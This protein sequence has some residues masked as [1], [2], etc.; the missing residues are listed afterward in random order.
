MSQDS[1]PQQTNLDS[2]IHADET[3]TP[4][5][6]VTT[7]GS[8]TQG[9]GKA[10]VRARVNGSSAPKSLRP[11]N[12]PGLKIERRFTQ[13][14]EDVYSTVEWELRD[15]VITNERGEKVFEQKNVEIP[16]SWTQLATNVVVSKYFRGH[17]GTP[18]RERSVRQ[19]ISRVAD[20][21]ANW[22]R[23][24]DYF[25]SEEDAQTFQDELTHILLHQKAAFNSPV[26]FNVGLADQPRPQSS[27]CFI[28]SVDDTMESILTLAKTEGMLFKYGSGTGTNLSPIRSSKEPLQGGGTASGPISF[29]RGYDMFAGA[30][31]SG[32]KCFKKGTLV[33]TPDG[34]FPIETLQI[35]DMV[36]THKGPRPVADFMPN[37]WKQCYQVRTQ[38]GYE[39]EVTRGHKFAYWNAPEGRFEVK[40]IEDFAPGESLYILVEPTEGGTS[41]PLVVPEANDGPRATTTAEMTFPTELTD[42]LAYILGLMYGD[43]ELRTTYP[44]RV[45][46]AFCKDA[47]GQASA[48]RFRRYCVNLFGEEPLLLSDEANHQQIGFT[49][50]RLIE[51]LMA[52]GIA[53]GKADKLGFPKML[54]QARREVRAAFI[55]GFLDADGTYQR[56]GGWS[57]SC[58]DRPFLVEMQRLLLTLG[59]PSKLYLRR[60][61]RGN[62]QPLYKL[63]IVGH[64]FISRL[65]QQVA[66]YSAKAALNYVPSDG[67]DKGW[68][69]R[70]SLYSALTSRVERRGGYRLVER[71]IGLNET[72]GYGALPQL[73]THPH[74]SIADYAGELSHTVQV[75]LESITP[76]EV[77]ETYDIEVA[78]VHLLCANGFYASN[79]RRAAKMVILDV[80]HPDIVDFIT[81]KEKEEKKAWALIDAGYSGAFNVPG[82]AYDSVQ[83]QNANHSVRVNDTF[84]R[85][86]EQ[87]TDFSTRNIL[88]KEV[89]ATYKARDL[90]KMIGQSAWVCGDPGMQYDTT[91]NKWHTCKNTDR[92]YASNPCSEYMFLNDSACNLA[93]LNLMKFRQADGE[94]DVE[95]FQHA[96]R[97][98][99]TAQEIIVDNAS[100]PTPRIAENSHDY[101][102]LGLGYANLGALL[103]AR[104]LPYDSDAGRAYAAAITAI[105]TGEAYHQSS[106]I[107]RD[108]GWPFPGYTKNREPFLN[109]MRMHRAAVEDIDAAS[110]PDDMLQ[111]A[112]SSWDNAI[113]KGEQH[114][115]R[116]AQATVLAPTGC[117]VGDSLV[118][119]GRG[120]VRLRGLGDPNGKQWQP[121][122]IEVAT[123]EGARQTSHFYVNGAEPVVTVETGRGYRIQGTPTHRIKVV[124]AGRQW[125]W[126]RF[127]DL[128][129]GD[130]VPLM[131]GGMV[132]T[133]NRVT[134]PP[135]PEAYWTSDHTTCAPRTMTA[136]LAEFVGYFIGDGSLHAKGLRFCVTAGD[137]D[138]VE[139]LTQ[140][141]STLFGLTPAVTDKRG[142]TEVALNSVRLTLWWEACGFAK[143]P[144]TPE[145]SG[146]GDAPHIPD[147]VLHTNDPAVYAAFLRGLFE[148]DGTVTN[149]YVSWSTT[150]ERFSRDVQSLLL[151]LGFVTTRKTEQTGANRWGANALY[152]LRLL[153]ASVAGQFG[154]EIGFLS[155][156]KQ[157]LLTAQEHPQAARY[158][159]IPLTREMVDE[160]APANDNLRKTLLLS[161]SHTGTVSR[162]A[163]TELLKRARSAKLG[164]LLGFFYDT[165]VTAELGEEQ[166]TYDLS[167]PDNVTYVANGFIS[168]NT[169]GFLMDCDT[170]GIEPD[171]AI[172]KYKTLVGGGMMKIVNNTVPEAL[173]RLGYTQ[174]QVDAILAYI[175]KN[176]TIEGAPELKPE[177]LPIF[178]CAF[179]PGNGTRSIHYMGHV[180]MMAAAQPFISGAISKCV[181]GDTLLYTERGIVPIRQFYAGEKPGN[182]TPCE[183][184]LGSIAAP[185]RADLFYYGGVRPTL[186]LTLAD[187]RTI[188]GTPNHR[189]KVANAQGYDWKRLDEITDQDYVAIRLGANV[190]ASENARIEFTPTKPYG[191]QKPVRIPERMTPELGRLLGCYIAEGNMIRTNWTV[192]ITNNDASVL[193][194]CQQIV[195]DLFG[196]EARIETDARNGVTSLLVA[197]KTLVELFTYLGCGDNS[198]TKAIPWAVLQSRREVVQE[199]IGGLWLDGYVAKNGRVALCLNSETLLRQ[200]QVVLNNFGIRAYLLRKYNKEYDKYYTELGLHGT[201]ARTF[202]AQ[203]TLDE[204]P[205]A[206]RLAEAAQRVKENYA[207]YSDVVPCYR[208]LMQAVIRETRATSNW[209]NLFDRRT[210]HLSWQTVKAF[211]RRHPLPELAEIIEN[212][213]HF[214]PIREIAGNFAEVYDFQV[215]ENHAFL[216]NGIVNHNTVNMPNDATPEEI[217]GTYVEGWKLG[218]K[219][220]AIYRDGSKRTQPLMTKKAEIV[221]EKAEQSVEAL[222][223]VPV[224]APAPVA[225]RPTRHKLPDERHSITHK[226]SIAGHDGY[227]T[228]G[229]YPDGS[230]GEIFLT[231]SKEGSTISGLMDSFATAI[232]LALQYGVP[233]QTLVDKFAHTRFEPSGVT[234]NPDI[235]FAKSIMDYIFRW[236]GGKFLPKPPEEQPSLSNG[237][238]EEGNAFGEANSLAARPNTLPVLTLTSV[239]TASATLDEQERETFQNQADAPICTE[240]GSLMVRNGACFKCLN[241]GS[242]FGC[243]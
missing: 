235:R 169:I 50:K 241:C 170:T 184:T 228:V 224:P 197:S 86:Y 221:E 64:T 238:A 10:V 188:E 82:G 22:G 209:R 149:G 107:A 193:A 162:R 152:S 231:M 233:L 24:M 183:I 220:I 182:F 35:G 177:H 165:V 73:K 192:R 84:M 239:H 191:C 222:P 90:M 171:I 96:C 194:R 1:T 173:S 138:V 68:G 69:Y 104:S 16:K 172:V 9:N 19:L 113:E 47:A 8:H 80:D 45:R 61:A 48:E 119:T 216:G 230:P 207:V 93:S 12:A 91:I 14:G 198:E 158:D 77:A 159:H 94:F 229:M 101:R 210:R 214:V 49:R 3:E 148:A 203:F 43:A 52:N 146:K 141:G 195:R 185:Q 110:V 168:H 147:A 223:A 243:S 227:I 54:F 39:I 33:A 127:A 155:Q 65:V 179:K 100:Y 126:R 62:W 181:T 75:K 154:D 206:Q 18:Q 17:I 29:M 36:L 189:V 234:N 132:G 204:A 129:P 112:R 60:E 150:T 213:I 89:A 151:A 67:A 124:D 199:F 2:V 79:T 242:V 4:A 5:N 95:T 57:L 137:T 163:A 116:N 109:V 87:D 131:L 56:R 166:F 176:D 118:L 145:H 114:G 175:D 140:L 70:P 212:G 38:E 15:A 174:A 83:F 44:Y 20:T 6:N 55:A 117:L 13:P 78:D 32:G 135:L 51:F 63:H 23:A 178:D 157:S 30:I 156:R 218:L 139:R 41:I 76:T 208:D 74:A 27:A 26:W 187:G 161:L 72:T 123:D 128:R 202:A 85:A 125:Q 71:T 153:N 136:D 236:L 31:K 225:T 186:R 34:W 53:K 40:P 92:I 160:L 143:L 226:F 21:M 66:P 37:G 217:V 103:M 122:G 237:H 240:C 211:Y 106:I 134:L 99:I 133:P 102:P 98:L 219:A 11:D 142:Y 232:S 25:A 201:D 97:I 115:Y 111:A 190:W 196:L 164:H 81:S 200:L 7:N 58:I 121:L 120:L 28:N 88:N 215:P 167:V 59:V 205:K 105:M 42:E 46:V 108:H 130:R 144:P 180:K